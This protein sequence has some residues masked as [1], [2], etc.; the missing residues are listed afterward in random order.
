MSD[1]AEWLEQTRRETGARP[2]WRWVRLQR[3]YQADLEAVWRAWTEVPRLALW[4]GTVSGELRPG[5]TVTM[6]FG[7]PQPTTSR[8]LVCEPPHRLVGTWTYGTSKLDPPDE[9]ELTLRP[10]GDGTLVT[11]EHRSVE[12]GSDWQPGVGAGWEEWFLRLEHGLRGDTAE[13]IAVEPLQ[14]ELA[15]RWQTT[16]AG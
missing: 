3:R 7:L 9:V 4:F 1:F 5:G 8:I 14:A 15:Q 6:D 12:S 13:A 10:D 2:P 11:V 16:A